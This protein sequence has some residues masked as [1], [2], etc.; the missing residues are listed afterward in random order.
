LHRDKAHIDVIQ[1]D[2]L[3]SCIAEFPMKVT[4]ANSKPNAS[5]LL[6]LAPQDVVTDPLSGGGELAEFQR[7]GVAELLNIDAL[8]GQVSLNEL[9]DALQEGSYNLLLV[10][11]H[12]GNGQLMISQ[13]VYIQGENLGRLLSQHC[14]QTCVLMSCESEDFAKAISGAGVVNVISTEAPLNNEIARK[15]TREFFRELVRSN[16]A[17]RAFD[18]ARSRL[19]TT[20]AAI[21]L[22]HT[23]D[24]VVSPSDIILREIIGINTKLDD[25][26]LAIVKH[27]EAR[28]KQITN[29]TSAVLQLASTLATSKN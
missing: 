27:D 5:H 16:S 3:A 20:E 25:I 6:V 11:S 29:L 7:N 10:V 22:L 19:T 9:S 1:L 12:S 18:Y 15:F 28:T 14:V 8:V 4:I 21:F 13:D 24:P 26:K 2:Y 23:N 17:R